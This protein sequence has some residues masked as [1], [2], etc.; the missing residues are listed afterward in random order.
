MND[1]A[2][3]SS[4]FHQVFTRDPNRCVNL[5][6]EQN[7]ASL[8]D[9]SESARRARLAEMKELLTRLTLVQ[10]HALS[11]DE[12]LDL[13]LAQLH[14]LAAVHRDTYEWAGGHAA[15]HTPSAGHD[16]G[17]GVFLLLT[18]DPREGGDRLADIVRRLEQVP[19][20]LTALLG[21]LEH[22]VERWVSMDKDKVAGLPSLFQ[23]V[24]AFAEREGYVDL[25]R[26]TRAI[27][28]A[29]AALADYVVELEKLP[30]IREFHVGA[31]TAKNIVK[32]RGIDLGLAELHT[33][34]RDYLAR[35]GEQIE[36]LRVTLCHKYQ[37]DPDTR[38]EE[39]EAF[40]NRRYAVAAPGDDLDIVLERYRQE[41]AL[42]TSFVEK[43]GLFPLF[44]QQNIRILKTP[45]FMLPSIPAGA[46]LPPAPF[47]SGPPTSQIYLSLSDELLNE[48]TA[49]SIPG[50]IIHE[51][52]P[53]HHLQ[54]AAAAQ[55]PSVIRKHFEA[56]D[57]AEGWTTMLEDY[58]LDQGY[59]PELADEARFIGKRDISRIGARVGIDLFFM[60]GDK[61]YLELG[62]PCDL[63]SEDPF[64]AAN[65]LLCTVTGFSPARAQAELN[66][67]SQERGYPLCYLTGNHLVWQLK[68]DVAQSQQGKLAGDALD[69]RFHEVY[70]AAGNMPLSLL[71]RVFGATGLL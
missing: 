22:P 16:I 36:G 60:T 58:M 48:H 53:G 14:L 8:P 42:A 20:Y 55:H 1:Y 59:M 35:T 6:V 27:T 66:W 7:L 49:L 47:R 68:A 10:P 19:D 65:E 23:S 51:A 39:L 15:R 70:L 4:A 61:S 56:M 28:R 29:E 34:A 21:R 33:I 18:N 13:E 5:G 32:L 41:L 63:S 17:S 62:V 31:A 52:M 25:S 71:R 64:V 24:S 9:P 3:F 38:V 30:A 37:L 2:A 40:L 26:L 44:E 46:M 50:M 11:S 67:Y 57:Q 45:P 43:S 69:R 54:L 12:R